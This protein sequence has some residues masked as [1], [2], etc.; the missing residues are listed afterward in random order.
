M[1]TEMNNNATTN[2]P[3]DTIQ[4]DITKMLTLSTDHI[5]SDMELAMLRNGSTDELG[6]TVYRYEFGYLIP[7][8]SS[9]ED[10][11]N[12]K[13]SIVPEIYALMEYAQKLGCQWLRFDE[14]GEIVPD[15]PTY[16]L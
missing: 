2:N 15:L 12:R 6:C 11:Q 8:Y 13:E 3:E 14:D 9:L 7:C 16:L 5:S 10:L 1:T 4:R